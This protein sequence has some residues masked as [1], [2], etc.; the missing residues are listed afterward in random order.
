MA[1]ELEKAKRYSEEAVIAAVGGGLMAVSEDAGGVI[2]DGEYA[3]ANCVRDVDDMLEIID[4][5]SDD[6]EGEFWV[7]LREADD[8]NFG[9]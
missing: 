9:T 5:S 6:D 8:A 7:R 3:S 2:V 1:Y 4:V